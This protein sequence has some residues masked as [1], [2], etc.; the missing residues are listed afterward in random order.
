MG[1]YKG[2]YLPYVE[3]TKVNYI[4]LLYLYSIAERYYT[5]TFD[6]LHPN[7]AI[8][9]DIVFKSWKDLEKKIN[10]KLSKYQEKKDDG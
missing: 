8:K 5:G 2:Y 10:C 7:E 6:P 4:Y 1:N 9:S 3:K